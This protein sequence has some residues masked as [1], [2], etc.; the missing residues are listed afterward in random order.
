MRGL[1]L[2]FALVGNQNSCLD[3]SLM[4]GVLN[5]NKASC[6]FD[7]QNK[8]IEAAIVFVDEI[9]GSGSLVYYIK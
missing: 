1:G 4:S 2:A 8:T 9:F 5:I 3:Q 7:Q 6:Y